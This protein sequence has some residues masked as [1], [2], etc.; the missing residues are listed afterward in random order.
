MA[1]EIHPRLEQLAKAFDQGR[2][3]Q[4]RQLLGEL[5][6]EDRAFLG[7][8]LGEDTVERLT[9][10]AARGARRSKV[11]RVAVINGIMGSLL[12]RRY[13]DTTTKRIWLAYLRLFNGAMSE[14][15]MGLDGGPADPDIE[16]FVSGLHKSYWKL[17]LELDTAWQV[18][19]CPFDWRLD[20]D[21]SAE[22][23]AQRLQHWAQGEPV[24]IVAHSMG[25]LVARRMIQRFPDLWAA[26]DDR[27]G[28][29][30]GGRLIML[31]TPN[32][33]SFIIPLTLTGEEKAV[34]RLALLDRKHGLKATQGTVS[35]F[36]GPY[37][38]LPSPEVDLGDEHRDLFKSSV[39]GSVPHH[40]DLLELGRRFQQ[41]MAQ[42]ESHDRLIYV[43][44]YDF[45]TPARVRIEKPGDFRYQTTLDGD[46]RVPHSLGLLDGVP[47]Y[48]VREAHGKLPESDLVLED[49]HGL[50]ATGQPRVLL[51][52]KPARRA[53]REE[54]RWL[55]GEEIDV[56]PL[57]LG[58]FLGG[59]SARRSGR[60]GAERQATTP[61][62]EQQAV[63][64]ALL[65]GG[66]VGDSL[67]AAA[68]RGFGDGGTKKTAARPSSPPL[69]LRVEVI[70]GDLRLVRGD[71]Y[72]VG[73][74]E[75]VLPQKAEW[76]LD[77]VVSGTWS[78]KTESKDRGVEGRQDVSRP[79][80]VL[81]ALTQNGVLGGQLGDV[82]FFPWSGRSIETWRSLSPESS[83]DETRG[84]KALARPDYFPTAPVVAVAGMGYPGTFN[85]ARLRRLARNLSWAV[86]LMPSVRDVCTVLIGSGEGGLSVSESLR[87][88][89]Q[90]IRDTLTGGLLDTS[91]E[92]ETL[93]I[94]EL[95]LDRAHEIYEALVEVAS[96]PEFALT[97][98]KD[99]D[100]SRGGRVTDEHCLSMVLSAAAKAQ[101]L[102]GKDPSSPEKARQ[103]LEALLAESLPYGARHAQE[104]AKALM[105]QV[106]TSDG[107]Q[108]ESEEIWERL[109]QNLRVQRK[110]DLHAWSMPTRLSFV[111]SDGTL[112]VAAIQTT[113]V[114]PEREQPIDKALID[115]VTRRL[116]DPSDAELE[117]YA[118][119][120]YH[121]LIPRDFRSKVD[122]E[123]TLIFEVDRST[124]DIPFEMLP[125]D[126]SDTDQP[127]LSLRTPVA[128]QL[129]TSYSPPP[130]A[131]PRLQRKAL[132]IGD[133]GDPAKGLDLPGARQEAR[134]AVEVLEGKGFQVDA[135]IGVPIARD[136]GDEPGCR[137][138]SRLEVLNLL[139]RNTYDLL[140]YC[141]HGD[142]DPEDPRRAGWVFKDGLLTASELETLDAVPQLVVAN[143]CLSS[144]LS[145]RLYGGKGSRG[146]A[147]LLPTL[148]DEFF[149][150]G[151][152]NYIGTAW[153]VSDAGAILFMEILYE[154]LLPAAP[155]K[156]SKGGSGAS[157]APKG[158]KLGRALLEARKGL[159]D[160]KTR[161]GALWAAYQHYGDPDL[162]LGGE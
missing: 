152:W 146:D 161:F 12:D 156:T 52:D 158:E 93:K 24:H 67:P 112:H 48:W 57:D 64:E 89:L 160:K 95:N 119:S 75:G 41:S 145:Q 29:R 56:E 118:P 58:P 73:H 149:R 84:A 71:V 53:L 72:C 77:E 31:G 153:E 8:Q 19:P 80:H 10:S 38:M 50:L 135:R 54:P 162:V 91:V 99:F 20:L 90:G 104:V 16:I 69:R 144:R 9:R 28:H 100:G 4:A 32:Q 35:T 113:A 88:L 157:H 42:V 151:V 147:G 11:G 17:L 25:G 65:T 101:I 129:R 26:L 33:G 18:L 139:R 111:R 34:R 116:T 102:G 128:R 140:H 142:F 159:W 130:M 150:R 103:A 30:R 14:L 15:R 94:V 138:A 7:L 68:R 1:D 123:Q 13:K 66:W 2:L 108:L 60:G 96:S 6:E 110:D 137:P 126:G 70:W 132:V 74:Y 82:H 49:I 63:A 86:G 62:L 107:A 45:E 27:E 121:F 40:P 78:P 47:T 44:G 61:S 98:D 43:A 141:G 136:L 124:A 117:E 87:G 133:P 55:S 120:L 106:D 59:P 122:F 39:W 37:Q 83:D 36:H 114:V 125:R 134:R 5:S 51:R 131:R 3:D 148:A 81:T 76:A 21:R 155:K 115:E 92:V 46:G 85:G 97:I 22:A 105:S 109:S 143:A 154:H 127:Y 23:L 79:T